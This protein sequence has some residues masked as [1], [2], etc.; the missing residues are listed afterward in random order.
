MQ[1][2]EMK[3]GGREESGRKLRRTTNVGRKWKEY[4]KRKSRK[5]GTAKM[6]GGE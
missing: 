5:R 3:Q 6:E 4:K 1:Q 2:R